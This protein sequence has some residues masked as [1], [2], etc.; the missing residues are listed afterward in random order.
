[1][2]RDQF[3]NQYKEVLTKPLK[4][5][6]SEEFEK[7]QEFLNSDISPTDQEIDELMEVEG[8]EV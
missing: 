1:M 7:L 2:E 4:E 5:L 3:F 8:C 6:T